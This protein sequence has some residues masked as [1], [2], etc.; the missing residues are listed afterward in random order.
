MDTSCE[1]VSSKDELALTFEHV[2]QQQVH[3]PIKIQQSLEVPVS[4]TSG[5]TLNQKDFQQLELIENIEPI[6]ENFHSDTKDLNPLEAGYLEIHQENI[7]NYL[8]IHP[9]CDET[10]PE[11]ILS[12][13]EVSSQEPQRNLKICYTL[14]LS[15][16]K[17]HML[18]IH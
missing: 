12:N 5:V 2:Q 3:D 17:F 6:Y 16:Y 8:E 10:E 9:A 4:D 15:L 14:G 7:P 18:T 1:Q 13:L 11:S